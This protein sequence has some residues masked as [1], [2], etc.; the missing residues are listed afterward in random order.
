MNTVFQ[1]PLIEWNGLKKTGFRFSFIFVIVFILPFPFDFLL[2]FTSLPGELITKLYNAIIPG[3][4]QHVLG[5]Q[6][7]IDLEVNG[8]GDKTMNYVTLFINFSLACIGALIWGLADRKRK[9]YSVLF[10]WFWVVCRYYM[11]FTMFGYGFA[12]VFKLQMGALSL[13][14]LVQP[15]GEQSP[16]GMAWNFIGFSDLYCRFS[17]WAEVIAGGLLIFNRTRL[18]GGLLCFVVMVHVMLL[19]FAYDIPVKIYSSFLVYLSII[20]L[21]PYFKRVIGVLFSNRF[22]NTLDEAPLFKRAWLNKAALGSK[23]LVTTAVLWFT[24]S[25]NTDQQQNYGEKAPPPPLYGIYETKT[26]LKNKDTIYAYA[27]SLAWKRLIFNWPGF[28]SVLKYNDQKLRL[29]CEVDTMKH[30]IHFTDRN[31][32]TIQYN[33]NYAILNDSM[34]QFTG[35]LKQDTFTFISLRKT[36]KDFLLYK[37]GFHWVN[38]YPF[39]R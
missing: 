20:I 29:T 19:N 12:K 23:Y 28:A 38:E 8:S 14:Q 3:I 18:L 1:Y 2:P 24:I 26:C 37:R 39:N 36:R 25:Q 13:N 9:S 6:E 34:Y 7:P 33:V 35:I 4:G 31:D 17:G 5:I 22:V 16:M 32:S 10:Y 30:H 11:A 21:S 15:I 27:D